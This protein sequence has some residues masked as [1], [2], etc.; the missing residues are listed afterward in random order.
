M[1]VLLVFVG[2]GLGSVLRYLIGLGF[3]QTNFQLP[4]ST[5][6]ANVCASLMIAILLGL[7]WKQNQSMQWTLMAT[8]FCGGLST[9]S[10][11]SLE[12]VELFR[13]GYQAI[14]WANILL[15]VVVCFVV[16]FVFYRMVMRG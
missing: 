15:N 4:L 2:G 16:V 7:G 14:A 5:L 3:K 10:T 8:G 12:T 9:F 6:L 1:N 11:F 13:E